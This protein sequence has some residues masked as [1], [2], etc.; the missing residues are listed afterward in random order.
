MEKSTIAILIVV[1][2]LVIGG[3]IVGLLYHFKVGI[4]KKDEKKEDPTKFSTYLTKYN[5]PKEN[6]TSD[7]IA[8]LKSLLDELDFIINMGPSG[9]AKTECKLDASNEKSPNYILGTL[10]CML[11]NDKT[12]KD[13]IA[14]IYMLANKLMN[15]GKS[16]SIKYDKDSNKVTIHK[17]DLGF[18]GIGCN[19]TN[20]ND[21]CMKNWYCDVTSGIRAF[22]C[23]PYNVSTC[24]E[25]SD[26]DDNHT[27]YQGK[28]FRKCSEGGVSSDGYIVNCN[29]N[30]EI[31]SVS[32]PIL[33]TSDN[34]YFVMD[35]EEFKN[36]CIQKSTDIFKNSNADCSTCESIYNLH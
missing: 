35:Y 20:P 8:I 14:S 1:G 27:C 22:S 33:S 5:S 11:L 23:M 13:Q 21:T 18:V 28:C 29:S 19:V 24:S 15:Q 7:K 6:F 2:L 4:F 30:M 17:K 10:V 3:I 25:E 12:T 16:I 34:D 26:C 31:Q 36:K 32:E 9:I